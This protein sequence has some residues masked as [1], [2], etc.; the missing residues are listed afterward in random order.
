[1]QHLVV[2]PIV[3]DSTCTIVATQSATVMVVGGSTTVVTITN[4]FV[5]LDLWAPWVVARDAHGVAVTDQRL[6]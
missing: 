4:L 5:P 6:S 3:N 1:M 2:T